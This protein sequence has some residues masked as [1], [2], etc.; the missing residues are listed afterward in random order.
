MK[1]E[2]KLNIGDKVWKMEDRKPL[3]IEIYSIAITALTEHPDI[4]YFA[5][6]KPPRWTYIKF[7]EFEFEDT[8]FRTKKELIN[9][10]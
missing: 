9:S 3:R 4:D 10:L 2:T 1:I 7:N 5:Q 6:E 8:V